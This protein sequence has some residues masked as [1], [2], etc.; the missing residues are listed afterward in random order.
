[1]RIRFD[2][3]RPCGSQGL[4]GSEG[5]GGRTYR[6]KRSQ[7][8]DES[9]LVGSR[10]SRRTLAR[11]ASACA[12]A[13]AEIASKDGHGQTTR[14]RLNAHLPQQTHCQKR[15]ARNRGGPGRVGVDGGIF[16]Q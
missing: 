9:V 5:G 12:S 4:G 7:A 16:E 6:R 2:V 8:I 11:L 14:P 10:Q 13:S 3:T 1:M 15:E